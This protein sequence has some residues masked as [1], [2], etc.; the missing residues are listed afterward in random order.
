MDQSC[1]DEKRYLRHKNDT[2]FRKHCSFWGGVWR[3]RHMHEHASATKGPAY[4]WRRPIPTS[5]RYGRPMPMRMGLHYLVLSIL[6]PIMCSIAPCKLLRKRSFPNLDR[7]VPSPW[8]C[9][10]WLILIW[11]CLVWP[12]PGSPWFAWRSTRVRVWF[13]A[14]VF[15]E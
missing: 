10:V 3:K 1:N 14:F 11:G 6:T 4:W 8:K 15:V 5:N 13:I 2:R 12:L 7:W 9:W